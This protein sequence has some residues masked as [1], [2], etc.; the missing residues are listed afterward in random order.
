MTLCFFSFYSSGTWEEG[1]HGEADRAE[2]RTILGSVLLIW[3]RM[4]LGLPDGSGSIS[5]RYGSGPA[6]DP[7]PDPSIIKQK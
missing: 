1:K 3:I 7:A 5:T 6:P 2:R 4:F